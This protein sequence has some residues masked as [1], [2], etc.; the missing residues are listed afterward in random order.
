[1]QIQPDIEH[2]D[3]LIVLAD[4]TMNEEIAS[5]DALLAIQQRMDAGMRVIIF[6]CKD[7]PMITTVGIALLVK[8]H[9]EATKMGGDFQLI[10]LSGVARD[11]IKVARLDHLLHIGGE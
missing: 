1:M 4:V 8:L 7:V 6:D 2:S 10:N 9:T 3:H 5:V 11:V